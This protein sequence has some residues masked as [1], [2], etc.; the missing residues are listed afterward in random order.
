MPTYEYE[1]KTCN[2]R[3]EVFQA[4]SDEPIKT[5]EKCQKEVR[6]LIF[7]GAGVI[8]KGSGFYVTD[9]NKGSGVKTASKS[10]EAASSATAA[11][12]ATAASSEA[13]AKETPSSN[14][15]GKTCSKCPAQPL[16]GSEKTA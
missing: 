14:A 3:F 2:H 12:S 1:C 16:C 4:I 11:A 13:S 5:C 9:K 8:F 7:G 15:D 6:R 10:S